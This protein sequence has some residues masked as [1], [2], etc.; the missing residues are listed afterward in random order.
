MRFCKISVPN[1]VGYLKRIVC[2]NI[3]KVHDRE[4]EKIVTSVN[5][6]VCEKE[7][8]IITHNKALRWPLVTDLVILNHVEVTITTS[9]LVLTIP[10][11]QVAPTK[12]VSTSTDLIF[13]GESSAALSSNS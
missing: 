7:S 11:F 2:A 8:D 3:S 1:V 9:E 5:L 6:Y 4:K 12:E 13:Y 10:N